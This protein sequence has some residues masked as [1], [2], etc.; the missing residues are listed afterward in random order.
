M[1]CR[2]PFVGASRKQ[3][4][5]GS[6]RIIVRLEVNLLTCQSLLM[7]W[8]MVRKP[9]CKSDA[10]KGKNEDDRLIGGNP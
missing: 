2:A 9:Y 1:A 5:D 7:N 10:N 6:T 4:V 8:W 3:A